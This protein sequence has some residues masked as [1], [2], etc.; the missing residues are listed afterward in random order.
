MRHD[1]I[2]FGWRFVVVQQPHLCY[3][4]RSYARHDSFICATGLIRMCAMTHLYVRH[5]LLERATW[6]IHM[7]DMT[8]SCMRYI[9]IAY[10]SNI[11]MTYSCFRYEIYEILRTYM[12]Y[13]VSHTRVS[14]VAHMRKFK[15]IAHTR[16]SHVAH[17]SK[18]KDKAH[19]AHTQVS[20]VAH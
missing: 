2:E 17:M 18:L 9:C 11:S 3:V 8:Y 16:V 6:L 13:I 14:H 15:N 10:T 19:T 4:T 1:E 7:C 5:N 12:C 20:H